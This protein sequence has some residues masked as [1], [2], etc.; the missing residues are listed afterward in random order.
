M[1]SGG[2][3]KLEEEG[4]E[5]ERGVGGEGREIGWGR[6]RGGGRE[7]GGELCMALE[8]TFLGHA[9]LLHNTLSASDCNLLSDVLALPPGCP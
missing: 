6:G 1:V 9:L 7:G 8:C 5:G 4:R 2:D 3:V